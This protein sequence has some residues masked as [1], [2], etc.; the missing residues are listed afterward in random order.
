MASL[1]PPEFFGNKPTNNGLSSLSSTTS[2]NLVEFRAGK[3]Y[4]EG[5]LCKPDPRKG[6]VYVKVVSLMSRY[7][8]GVCE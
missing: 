3:M 7:F 8:W 6:L 1:F 2:G 5:R 4:V